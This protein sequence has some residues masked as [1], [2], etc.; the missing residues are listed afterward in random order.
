MGATRGLVHPGP[1]AHHRYG[2]SFGMQVGRWWGLWRLNSW[3]VSGHSLVT[4]YSGPN[5]FSPRFGS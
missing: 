5:F 1:V 2:R 4:S 3:D